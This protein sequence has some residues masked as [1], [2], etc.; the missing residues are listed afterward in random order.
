MLHSSLSHLESIDQRF[1]DPDAALVVM[2]QDTENDLDDA[3]LALD[4]L[5]SLMES[6]ASMNAAL[7][8]AGR[9]AQALEIAPDSMAALLRVLVEKIKPATLNPTLNAVRYVRPDLFHAN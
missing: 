2:C 9:A 3:R 8:G 6:A 1:L 5:A 4:G 7:R